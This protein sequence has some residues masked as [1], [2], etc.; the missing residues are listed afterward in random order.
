MNRLADNMELL[1]D[2]VENP[3]KLGYYALLTKVKGKSKPPTSIELLKFKMNME[4]EIRRI[5]RKI[6]RKLDFQLPDGLK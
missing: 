1:E 6:E 2:L 5:S 3:S 4:F